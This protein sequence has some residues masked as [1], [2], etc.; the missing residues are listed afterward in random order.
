[1]ATG[2]EG[3]SPYEIRPMAIQEDMAALSRLT[4]SVRVKF[5]NNI[6]PDQIRNRP[7]PPLKI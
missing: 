4:I 7:F 5:T 2:F 3:K 1:M 6:E